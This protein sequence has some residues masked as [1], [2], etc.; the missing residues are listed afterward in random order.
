M[1]RA[2][3]EGIDDVRVKYHLITPYILI[4]GRRGGYKN[5]QA[6]YHAYRHWQGSLGYPIVAVGGEELPMGFPQGM[7]IIRPPDEDLPALYSGASAL[8]YPSYAEG[9]GLPVLDALAC[10]CPVVAGEAVREAGGDG[11]HYCDVFSP[12][13]IVQ[14]LDRAVFDPSEQ[15]GYTLV[16][17]NHAKQFT[18]ERMAQKIAEVIRET[19]LYPG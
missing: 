1:Q 14:A 9:F 17:M 11:V 4:V 13:S 15:I 5:G 2:S 16:G 7:S 6:F 18:W 10:G 3:A 19:V 12:Q 8:V